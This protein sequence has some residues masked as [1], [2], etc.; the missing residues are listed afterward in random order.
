MSLAKVCIPHSSSLPAFLPTSWA[1]SNII[2]VLTIPGAY[3]LTVIPESAKSR[4]KV[5]VI[6]RTANLVPP[7]TVKLGLPT[8]PAC[9]VALMILPPWPSALNCACAAW[10]PQITPPTLMLNV[11]WNCSSVIVSSGVVGATPAL[12]TTTFKSP[13]WST[14]FWKAAAT[15]ACLDTS[16]T[17]ANA[18][19]ADNSA[20]AFSAVSAL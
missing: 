10:A 5:W 16:A 12:L 8:T 4:A 3:A 19:S 1:M 20:T 13:K 2:G 15:S 17:T 11:R 14:T 9:E 7:Y 18:L 6:P